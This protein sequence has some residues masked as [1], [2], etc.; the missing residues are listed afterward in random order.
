MSK[1]HHLVGQGEPERIDPVVSQR[2]GY[3]RL[4]FCF[5]EP[6]SRPVDAS[7]R[8]MFDDNQTNSNVRQNLGNSANVVL[9]SDQQAQVCQALLKGSGLK[10]SCANGSSKVSCSTEPRFMCRRQAAIGG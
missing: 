2:K 9:T 7:L 6:E 4:L 8:Q 5:V 3:R 10:L 1:V